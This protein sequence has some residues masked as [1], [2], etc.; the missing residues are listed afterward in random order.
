MFDGPA[1]K[2]LGRA[3]IALYPEHE[4]HWLADPIYRPVETAPLA[5]NL[6]LGL[7]NTP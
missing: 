3:H 2:G 7:V 6:Q 5:T 1:E 4:V